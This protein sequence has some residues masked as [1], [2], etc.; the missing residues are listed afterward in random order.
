MRDE[1]SLLQAQLTYKHRLTAM[2]K[3]LHS[4]QAPLRA[5]AEEL[6]QLMR[7]EQKDVDR[8]ES[9]SLAAFFY[10]VVGKMDE[11]L[12]MERRE[13]YAARVKYDACL[14]ELEA[15]EQDI[16]A[17]EE[18][19][20]DLADCE[21][22]YARA[23][24]AKRLA[25][26]A[27]GLPVS[28]TLLQEEQ[29]LSYLAEQE[30]EL[31]EAIAAGTTALRTTADIMQQIESAKDWATFDLLGG[32]LL[33]DLA[34]HEKLDEAQKEVEALQVQLQRFN[35]ELS[36]VTI[37]SC[38]QVNIDD[39]LKFADFFF[40]GLLADAAVLEHIKQ[41]H[42]QVEQTRE[43]ILTIL[44]QLQDELEDV[45]QKYSRLKKDVD[46]LILEAEL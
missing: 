19:L 39:M 29:S 28:E 1:L 22:K 34:K 12:D 11:K 38:L 14:R 4:Q 5:K 20:A 17:T 36:D 25:I 33:A 9:H 10:N 16:E 35:K 13:Y 45:R 44:R 42:A 23:V 41:S 18:D 2:L 27:A 31:E 6:E 26:E 30:R 43:D 37:R 15:V 7:R 3:E 21:E 32:G 40:D 8:L 46:A 24:E